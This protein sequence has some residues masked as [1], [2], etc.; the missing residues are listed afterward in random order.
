VMTLTIFE[1]VCFPTTFFKNTFATL[2][3][4]FDVLVQ[5]LGKGSNG[6]VYKSLNMDTGDVVA[7]KQVQI[8]AM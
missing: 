1:P 6:V 4:K 8:D 3:N 2:A 5:V 7:I